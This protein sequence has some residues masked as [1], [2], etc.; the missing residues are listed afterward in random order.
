MKNNINSKKYIKKAYSRS[1]LRSFNWATKAPTVFPDFNFDNVLSMVDND[2][3]ARGAVNHFVDKCMEGEYSLIKRE[4]KEYDRMAELRLDEKYQFRTKIL[5]KIFLIG[6]LFNNVFLELVKDLDGKTKG[7]NILDSTIIEPIT[8]TNG[9]V[10]SYRSKIPD[11]KTGV[12]AEWTKDEIVWYRFGERTNS[13]AP[14]DFRAIANIL[15]MKQYILRYTSWLWQTG[16]YRLVY[17]FKDASDQDIEN[18]LAFNRKNDEFYNIPF[19]M[20]GEMETKLLRD[21]K[22][23]DSLV[24]LLKYIDGQI[25]ILLRVPP[26]DAGIPDA[27]GRSNADAQSNNMGTAVTSV[28]K[29]VEDTTNFDLFP[30]IGKGTYLLVFAPVDRFAEKQV[31]EIVQIMKSMGMTD[32]V[33]KEFMEDRGMF[34]TCAR[35]FN[36]P[37]ETGLAAT[38]SNPRDKD[39]A[40][41]RSGKGSQEGNTKKEAVTTREDQLKKV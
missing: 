19:I 20:K 30:K 41:S 21:M 31:F 7:I 39:T 33:C 4:T 13:Y 6:K 9:D 1:P 18:W 23:T 32:E 12:H 10:I 28:K 8:Q 29:V 15:T 34:Y 3:V 17:N 36:D 35:I 22:E 14:V 16:Q 24:S 2:P 25:L 5:R 37:I 38:V 27:S 26:I 40:P 11:V